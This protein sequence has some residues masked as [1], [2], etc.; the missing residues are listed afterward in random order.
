MVKIREESPVEVKKGLWAL[1][2]KVRILEGLTKEVTAP[3]LADLL[4]YINDQCR[5]MS[6]SEIEKALALNRAGEFEPRIQ[7]YQS[8]NVP[9]LSEVVKAYKKWKSGI[10]SRFNLAMESAPQNLLPEMSE[11]QKMEICKQGVKRC[12]D[13]YIETQIYPPGYSYVYDILDEFGKMPKSIEEKRR[14]YDLAVSRIDR[15]LKSAK[16]INFA[17]RISIKDQVDQIKRGNKNIYKTEAR[18]MAVELLFVEIKDSNKSFE[19]FL[20]WN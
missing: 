15:M 9:F 13:V 11:S 14:I 10:R 19:E 1:I 8:F 20:E 17:H 2:Q 3:V 7:H 6:I 16:P 18:Q 12:F 5:N 4:A